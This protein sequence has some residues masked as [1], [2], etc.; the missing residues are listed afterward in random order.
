[1]RWIDLFSKNNP[2]TEE[3]TVGFSLRILKYICHIHFQH[4]F[5]IRH[6]EIT[7]V[8]NVMSTPLIYLAIGDF[9]E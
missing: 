8:F 1:M 6:S 2:N 7:L 4:G 5:T 9:V 3:W